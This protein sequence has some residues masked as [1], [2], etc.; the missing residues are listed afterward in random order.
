MMPYYVHVLFTYNSISLVVSVSSLLASLVALLMARSSLAQAKQVAE[1]DQRDWRQ[2]KWFDLYFKADEARDSLDRFQALYPIPTSPNW[3]T[4]KW[5]R[6]SHDLMLTMRTVHRIASV[7]PQ[8]PAITS[9][10]T[11]TGVFADINE[12][13]SAARVLIIADAVEGIRQRALVDV[14]VL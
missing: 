13:T 2:R 6:D 11:A 9:L 1:R 8:D 5:Q 4:P 14:S 10:F 7:F 12:A 3:N